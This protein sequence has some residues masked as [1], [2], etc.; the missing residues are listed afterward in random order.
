VT[1]VSRSAPKPAVRK[2][3]PSHQDKVGKKSP[4]APVRP[5]PKEIKPRVPATQDEVTGSRTCAA[6]RDQEARRK[7][8]AE[9]PET[10]TTH[11]AQASQTG[12]AP[13]NRSAAET[14]QREDQP[15]PPPESASVPTSRADAQVHQRDTPPRSEPPPGEPSAPTP[16]SRPGTQAVQGSRPTT[17]SSDLPTTTTPTG[18]PPIATGGNANTPASSSE[19]KKPSGPLTLDQLH[20]RTPDK[21]YDYLRGQIEKGGGQFKT[22]PGER[23]L[24]TMKM[25]GADGKDEYRTFSVWMDKEGKKHVNEYQ[26]KGD[27]AAAGLLAGG[28]QGVKGG[29]RELNPKSALTPLLLNQVVAPEDQKRFWADA[30]LEGRPPAMGYTLIPS[31]GK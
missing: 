26:T 20:A 6:A 19:V 9:L 27:G 24:V 10:S 15:Q 23:N 21:Q 18:A 31:T 28:Q 14:Y 22:G 25:R 2:V 11:R 16:T 8:A 5:P 12:S 13:T 3:E 7:V 29:Y 1:S 30:R 4:E 17:P